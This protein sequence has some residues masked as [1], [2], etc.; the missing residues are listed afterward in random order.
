ML[1][2][3]LQLHVLQSDLLQTSVTTLSWFLYKLEIQPIIQITY[4]L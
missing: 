4:H 2:N 3:I 1:M